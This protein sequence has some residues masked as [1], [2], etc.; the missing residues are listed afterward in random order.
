MNDHI[1]LSVARNVALYRLFFTYGD[2][3]SKTAI[4]VMRPVLGSIFNQFAGSE[5]REYLR[6]KNKNI[7]DDA[8]IHSLLK[9][10]LNVQLHKMLGIKWIYNFPCS[11]T[12]K[13]FSRTVLQWAQNIF[14]VIICSKV[15][16]GQMMEQQSELIS[17]CS[18]ANEHIHGQTRS[19][20]RCVMKRIGLDKIYWTETDFLSGHGVC[21]SV[22]W[23]LYSYCLLLFIQNG[24]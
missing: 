7:Y 21:Y 13:S 11:K 4:V 3:R 23:I 20:A 15:F 1:P 14:A 9:S 5:S 12:L 19:E 10:R 8:L 22:V 16:V 18:Q 2:S 17:S 24:E 6:W